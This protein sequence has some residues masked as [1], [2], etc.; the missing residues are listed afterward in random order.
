MDL[1]DLTHSQQIKLETFQDSLKFY[2]S[3]LGQ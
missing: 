1:A 2:R 3:P